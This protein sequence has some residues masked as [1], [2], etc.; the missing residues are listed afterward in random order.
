M[1]SINGTILIAL[2]HMTINSL[3]QMLSTSKLPLFSCPFSDLKVAFISAT[4]RHMGATR[5]MHKAQHFSH[6]RLKTASGFNQFVP[7]Q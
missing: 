6:T 5:A 4:G 7:R 2:S 3:K 1:E